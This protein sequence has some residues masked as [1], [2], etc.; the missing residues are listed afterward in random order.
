MIRKTC[1]LCGSND[2]QEIYSLKEFPVY[3]GSTK[4][5]KE[6]DLYEDL[7]FVKCGS[8]GSGQIKNMTA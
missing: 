7:T 6:D 5:K 8:C 2:L 3:M 1:F 4:Q